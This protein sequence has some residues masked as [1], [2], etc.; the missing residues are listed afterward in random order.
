MYYPRLQIGSKGLA[1]LHLKK[2]LA[3]K[4]LHPSSNDSTYYSRTADIVR[5]YQATHIGPSG[6]FLIETEEPGIV[7][8]TTWMALEGRLN[9]NQ[10][11]PAPVKVD[12]TSSSPRARFLEQL[13]AWYKAGVR[14]IPKGSNADNG[15]VISKME[16]F[17]GMTGQPWCAMTINYAHHLVFG[18]LPPWGK[19]AR[20]CSLWNVARAK[21]LTLPPTAALCPGDLGVYISKPLRADGTAP[22]VN[23]HIFTLTG[24]KG[25]TIYGID[26]NSDD[27]VRASARSINYISGIIRLWPVE[28]DLKFD[29]ESYESGTAS[30]R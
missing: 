27:R 19:N 30:D 18:V 7:T 17:H 9:Q 11:A 13:V 2:L 21:G 28:R 6:K 3:A 22:D 20:V 12:T 29:L 8:D 5:L 24:R 16:R 26:G 15:G 14:E 4:G 23:G 10:K 1:V 25:N